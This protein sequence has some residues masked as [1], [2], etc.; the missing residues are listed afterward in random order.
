MT[1]VF[2]ACAALGGAILIIQAGLTMIGIGAD[3]LDV[4]GVD[5]PDADAGFDVDGDVH[6][7]SSG[8]FG[9]ISFRTVVAGIT[10]FG[11]GGLSAEGFGFETP[12]QVLFAAGTGAGALYGVY[13]LMLSMYSL[14]TDP[15]VRVAQAVGQPATVYTP[16]PA[17]HGGTGKILVNLQQRTLE[18]R[19]MTE[20]ARLPTGSKVVVTRMITSDTFDV[21]AA[22]EMEQNDD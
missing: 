14:R 13:W 12:M 3:S 6:G 21:V 20:G 5:V 1:S 19:A 10:F 18:C 9:I 11:L 22:A 17:G 16:I 8:A 2:L 7:D 15:T 4:D